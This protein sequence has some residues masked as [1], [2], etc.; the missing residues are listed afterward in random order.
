M[1]ENKSSVQDIAHEEN[2]RAIAMTAGT[3]LIAR[4]IPYLEHREFTAKKYFHYPK[5]IGIDQ[6]TKDELVKMIEHCNEEIKV[7]LGL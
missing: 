6:T 4:L 1:S 7:I 3:R 5:D 2:K